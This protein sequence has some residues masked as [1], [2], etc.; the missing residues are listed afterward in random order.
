MILIEAERLN[1]FPDNWTDTMPDRMRF[2]CMGNAL[3]VPIITRIAN[4]IE[5]IEINN[6]DK[7]SQL[8]LF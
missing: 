8:E 2:F 1:G 7:Y 6:N 3:V 5:I 4:Q